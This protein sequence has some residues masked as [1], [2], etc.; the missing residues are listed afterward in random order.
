MR[1][2]DQALAVAPAVKLPGVRTPSA[3]RH[4]LSNGGAGLLQVIH[5][6]NS[7]GMRAKVVGINACFGAHGLGYFEHV[8]CRNWLYRLS[9]L[10]E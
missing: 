7:E 1:P 9:G 3:N 4:D 8:G 6:S 10:R 2:D 5:A